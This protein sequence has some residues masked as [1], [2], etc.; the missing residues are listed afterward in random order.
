MKDYKNSIFKQIMGVN[1][2]T[3]KV[4]IVCHFSFFIIFFFLSNL[5]WHGLCFHACF[6]YPNIAKLVTRFYPRKEMEFLMSFT[7]C[8]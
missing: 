2:F 4:P 8:N 1:V 3:P 6:F 7:D 5:T